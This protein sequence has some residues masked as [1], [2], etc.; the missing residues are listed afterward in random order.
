MCSRPAPDYHTLAQHMKDKHGHEAPSRAGAMDVTLDDLLQASRCPE[1]SC[2]GLLYG[3]KLIMYM[4]WL[5]ENVSAAQ[6]R[7]AI[8]CTERGTV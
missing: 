4:A 3:C 6:V 7:L 2:S 8:K 1:A 5:L